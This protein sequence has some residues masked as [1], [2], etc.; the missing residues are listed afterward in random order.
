MNTRI[1]YIPG[2]GDRY[3]GFRRFALK[4]WRIWGVQAEFVPIK[5]YDG[6]GYD[7]KMTR[8]KIAIEQNKSNRLV[9]FGESAGATLALHAAKAGGVDRVVTVCGVA[10]SHA[11]ISSYLNKKAPALVPATRTLPQESTLD[12]HSV[13]AAIDPVV[14]RKYSVA[15]GATVHKLW[16]I[17]HFTTI[18]LCLTVLSPLM[19]TIAKKSKT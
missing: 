17:G 15:Q 5:W 2:L 6:E 18:V 10:T 8:V 14:N 7:Q 4:L 19:V 11:P 12:V 9:L 13:R 16:T 3:D 1:V